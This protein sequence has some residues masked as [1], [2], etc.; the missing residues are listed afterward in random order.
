M[1]KWGTC[2]GWCSY[3]EVVECPIAEKMLANMKVPI[4][5]I[6]DGVWREMQLLMEMQDAAKKGLTWWEIKAGQR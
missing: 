6:F 2:E 4:I 5:E 3:E 1:C